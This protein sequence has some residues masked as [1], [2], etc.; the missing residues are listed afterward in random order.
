M[1]LFI[2]IIYAIPLVFIFSYSLVQLSLIINYLGG[3]QLA[4]GGRQSA[5]GGWQLFQRSKILPKY[6]ETWRDRP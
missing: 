4:V 3:L 2:L 6:Y 1:E 5:V